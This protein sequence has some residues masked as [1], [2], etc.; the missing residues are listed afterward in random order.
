MTIVNRRTHIAKRGHRQEVIE[1]LK[2][3][4][5]GPYVSRVSTAHYG[6]FDVAVLEVEFAD[7]AAMEAGW[8]AWFASERG[9]N[10]MSRWV[11]I[12]EPG[13]SNEVWQ[14]T[15]QAAGGNARF[16][17]RRT[18]QARHGQLNAL[19]ELLST[20]AN[21]MPYIPPFRI[22]H[23]LFGPGSLA[24]LE[25]EFPEI[26]AHN[27]FWDAFRDAPETPAVMERFNQLIEPPWT[28]EIW[29]LH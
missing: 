21:H 18:F 1:M 26:T 6:P 11:E 23:S 20:G 28:N 24:A 16:V 25:I 10:F 15:A 5:G 3:E 14:I 29:Q 27:E 8:N 9:G 4:E 19:T 13:G 7:L 12:T 17:N 2:G 22:S